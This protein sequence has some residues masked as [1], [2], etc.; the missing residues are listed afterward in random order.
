MGLRKNGRYFRLN[1]ALTHRTSFIHRYLHI[2][3]CRAHIY[4][5]IQYITRIYVGTPTRICFHGTGIYSNGNLRRIQWRKHFVKM[6]SLAFRYFL[7]PPVF[8]ILVFVG[9]CRNLTY[10]ILRF[11]L[12][13]QELLLMLFSSFVLFGWIMCLDIDFTVSSLFVTTMIILTIKR[14]LSFT[15]MSMRD[16]MAIMGK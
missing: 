11:S 4:L 10:A 13:S 8:C 15:H 3:T 1:I 7:C 6:M 16:M 2:Y 14:W 9:I 5:K 12:S